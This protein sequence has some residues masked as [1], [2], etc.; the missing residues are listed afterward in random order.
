MKKII[1]SMIMFAGLMTASCEKDD[2]IHTATEP[3]AGEWY[4]TVDFADADGNVVMADPYGIGKFMVNTYNTS[5]NVNN[6]MWVDDLGNFWEF[7]LKVN[8]DIANL[9][10]ASNDTVPNFYYDCGVI[11]EDGKML[12][13]AA[14]TPSGV[15]ADSIV[16]YVQFTDDNLAYQEAFGYTRFKVSGYR[17]TGFT[18]DE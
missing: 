5:A 16:F 9:T 10:F 8:C 2:I 13:K 7:K 15:P 17:Y 3:L 6:E 14:T 11:I 4:V 18:A 12:P 1:Y